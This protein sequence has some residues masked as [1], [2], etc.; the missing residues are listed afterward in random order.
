MEPENPL[1]SSSWHLIENLRLRLRPNLQAHR[2]SYRGQLWHVLH[3][4]FNNNFYRIRPAVW[5]F[6]RSLDGR[7]SVG[8]VWRDG[9]END[10]ENSP[11]QEELIRLVAQLNSA[12]L[13]YSPD[14]PLGQ[15]L[16]ERLRKQK[17]KK[18]VMQWINFLFL[19]IPLVDPDRFLNAFRWLWRIV[20]S[21]LG[22]LVWMALV[23]LGLR[24]A[25]GNWQELGDRTAMMLSPGNL[26]LLYLCLAVVKLI[27]ETAHCAVCKRFG[28]EVHQLG[29]L[30]LV[31]TPLPYMDATASW[32]F[33]ER[34]KRALTGSAGM[35]AEVA[36]AAIAAVIWANTDDPLVHNV[37]YNI[38]FIASV[39]TL[40]FNINPLL[41]FDGYYILSDLLDTPNLHQHSFAQL[42]HLF[43]R[44]LLG[45]PSKP[46][47]HSAGR[48]LFLCLF[49]VAS[50]IY[51]VLILFVILMYLAE[52]FF[53]A[54]LLLAFAGAG[55][56]LLVPLFR[57]TRWLLS[58]SP[59]YR[60]R[61]RLVVA[62]IVGAIFA[63]LA[64]YPFPRHFRAEGVLMAESA[65]KIILE[66]P[67]TTVSLP[68]QTGSEIREGQKMLQL[69]NP[70]IDARLQKAKASIQE[71]EYR[72]KVAREREISALN[73][74]DSALKVHRQVYA[75][76]LRQKQMLSVYSPLEGT[77][78]APEPTRFAGVYL[79]RGQSLGTIINDDSWKF[80]AVVNQQ[81]ASML[82][83]RESIVRA[84]VR[85]PG[86]SGRVIPVSDIRVV[87]AE[88]KELPSAALSW[89]GGGEMPS[90]P[91][92]RD[93]RSSAVPFF[94]VRA[95]LRPPATLRLNHLRTGVIRFELQPM[96]LLQ[97][98]W[99][100]FR[101]LVQKRYKI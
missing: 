44:Y 68:P 75:E 35:M 52:M 72:R 54:G 14:G 74:V 26:P 70:A 64:F 4:G 21:P 91:G 66:S 41:R 18:A 38:M 60:I 88:Q 49:S 9:L 40:L 30:L 28:G 10:P 61:A 76:L 6:L 31:F 93:G 73:S 62:S 36:L 94:K 48:I 29:V 27:H 39:S 34:W 16:V 5:R 43:Q 15:A 32:A 71:M 90:D 86:N 87:P 82:F 69:K 67:G 99:H 95:D 77:W 98:A 59:P 80:S 63:F 25:A 23:V 8:E 101:Q 55:L 37:A 20:V 2:Q 19:R 85:L 78:S 51:R 12:G 46:V 89:H 47:E 65:A 11:G 83:D 79:P 17:K 100:R 13:L 42:K 1:F 22:A 84:E 7:R 24:A 3:D 53:G 97:Q 81:D 58:I 96:P 33:R 56:W 92:S 57:F 45:L 50:G